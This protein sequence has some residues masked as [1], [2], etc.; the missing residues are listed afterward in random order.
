MEREAVNAFLDEAARREHKRRNLLHSA[1]L[2]GGLGAVLGLSAWLIWGWV[3]IIWAVVTILLVL[4][5]VPHVSPQAVMRMYRAREVDPRFGGP[6]AEIITIL[7]ERAELPAQPRLFVIPSSTLNAFATGQP[8]HAAIAV[9]EGLLRCLTTRELAGVLAHEISHI[10]NNDLWVMGLADAISRITTSL[11]CIAVLLALFNGFALLTGELYVSWWAVLV[12]YL[13]PTVSSLLQL[14]LSRAREYDADLEG[15][16]LTGDPMA[17]ASALRRLERYTGS[18]WEDLMFPV[19]GRRIPQPS[20]LRSHP[21]TEER[22]ARLMQLDRRRLRPIIHVADEPLLS[23][24]GSTRI[25]MR[26]RY[27]WPGVWF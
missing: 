10:R 25:G 1:L 21:T 5:L 9:T 19:P 15:A 12:L 3:G 4:A 7:A 23:L 14:A 17:L 16:W 24:F 2:L 27:R 22:V 20:L 11:S 6:L 18:F 8:R 26:P 13:A